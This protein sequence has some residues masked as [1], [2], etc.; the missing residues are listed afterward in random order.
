[1]REDFREKYF[2]LEDHH[3]WFLARR[4]LIS[5]LLKGCSRDLKIIDIGCSG[6]PLIKLLLD[7]GFSSVRGLD[8]DPGAIKRCKEKG[9]KN[10]SVMDARQTSFNGSEFDIII[11]SDILE[12][13]KDQDA[14]LAEWRRILRPGGKLFVFVPAFDLLWDSHD[15]IN[16]HYRRYSKKK[17]LSLLKEHG[18]R[19][20]RS[21]YS[22]SLTFLPA[23]LMKA[24]EILL[25]RFS[26]KNGHLFQVPSW[27]NALLAGSLK[28]ES[29]W[30]T[31]HSLVIGTGLFA[32]A[33]KI[34]GREDLNLRPF[35]PEPNALPG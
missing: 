26:G 9:L 2:L 5:S 13:I 8:I 4:S 20:V 10:I 14:A 7:Q 15:E 27:M 23:C 16:Q 6:G 21:S 3:W 35:G 29:R 17:L 30:L 11:A 18:F 32:V 25:R 19:I 22:N 28:I 12:H 31:R 33:E 24:S 1:M 34:S